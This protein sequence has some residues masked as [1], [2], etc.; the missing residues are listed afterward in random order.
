[1]DPLIQ[2]AMPRPPRRRWGTLV[3]TTML[4]LLL[5]A[6]AAAAAL[7]WYLYWPNGEHADPD[8]AALNKAI[9]YQGKKMEGSALGEKESVK[10]PFALV[11]QLVDPTIAYDE[12]SQSIIVTTQDKVIRMRTDQLTGTINEK[13]FTLRFPVEKKGDTLYV[14]LDPL[15]ET[16]RL[17]IRE[18]AETG[19]V[20]L[21]REGDT[22]QW[23]KTAA[24]A[25]HP[26]K[27]RA[28]R[29][30]PSV[31]AL[32]VAD[33]PQGDSVMV[34]EDTGVWYRIQLVNGVMGYAKKTDVVLDRIESIPK[35]EKKETFVP[36]RPLGGRIN[37]TWQQ[38]GTKNPDTSK[39][40]AMPGLNV[41]SPQWFHL[42]DG[43]GNLK[44][45]ADASF[46]KWARSQNYQL[47]AL[48]SNGF[49]PK[50]TSEALASYD[51]RMKMIKQIVSYAQM[52]GLQGINIDFE[53]VY[54]KDKANMVQ[55]VRELTP[56]LHEAGLVVSIDVTVRDGSENY[57]LFLDRRALGEVVDY[58]I[59]MTYDEHWSTSQVAGSV[60]S[61]PW[62]EKG[63]TQI[64]KEDDVP[65]SKIVLGVPYYTRIWTEQTK[66]GKTA[67]TSKAV[68]MD[69][70]QQI[71]NDKKLTPTFDAAAGQNYVQYKEGEQTMKIW[72]ED[73][74]SM[75]SRVELLK[76]LDLAG[77]ASWSRGFETPDI[78]TL[79]KDT[80]EKR[81]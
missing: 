46:A 2:P 49:D 52:Y 39:I 17:D 1:M 76:K 28:M 71:I 31:K 37:L 68:G 33:V 75:K 26:L 13:P 19:A 41:I 78:W 16:Y 7:Y 57:S 48:F 21:A 36:W 53:N 63:I 79:I 45:M 32:I 55:F 40:P 54:L 64:M 42:A 30:E 81:P 14:P 38:V 59:V 8:T 50:N 66:D 22:I 11:K 77:I 3:A 74:M 23:G 29:T 47:W 58:M 24:D 18:S 15:R 65:A 5:L 4:V 67:V 62:V 35:Q 69:A 25:R 70:V 6:M 44:N 10:L 9:F 56:L 72:I 43:D 61:L 60:A 27:S 80:L 51:K 34:W 12:K 20:L 73:A